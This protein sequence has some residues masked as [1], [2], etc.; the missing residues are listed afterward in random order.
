MAVEGI[1]TYYITGDYSSIGCN[2][3][4]SGDIVIPETIGGYTVNKILS[5]GFQNPNITSIV[6]PNS[7]TEISDYAFCDCSSLASINIP[8]NITSIGR[9]AF[10]NTALTSFNWPANI[11]RI[12]G[13]C[14]Y[15]SQLASINIPEG[16][17][18]IDNQAFAWSQLSDINLPSTILS[19]GVN[20]FTG[21]AF[22]DMDW[23]PSN[24][25]TIPEG[26]LSNNNFVDLI[27]PNYIVNIGQYAFSQCESLTSVVIPSSVNII[28]N[29]AFCQCDVLSKVIMTEGLTTIGDY[30]FSLC[31]KL[32]HLI[33]PLSVI[34]ITNRTF[35]D[36][37]EYSTKAIRRIDILSDSIVIH[38]KRIQNQ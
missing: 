35:K 8:N 24:I 32:T 37:Y 10:K 28:S 36:E 11:N 3:S 2:S 1:F 12:P 9:M 5:Y 6:L 21:C 38:Y 20:T 14:F 17:K 22:T 33:I 30:V 7:I 4:A 29:F 34:N 15:G 16:V 19:F 31:W 27:I 25:T 13:S 26:C 18:Y 23:W